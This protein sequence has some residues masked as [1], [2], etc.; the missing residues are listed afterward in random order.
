M[1]SALKNDEFCSF[2]PSKKFL[3]SLFTKYD[4]D[5]DGQISRAEFIAVLAKTDE[6]E[7]RWLIVIRFFEN[8]HGFCI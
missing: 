5:G 6:L 4:M 7:V 2:D 3:K 8:N 1:N